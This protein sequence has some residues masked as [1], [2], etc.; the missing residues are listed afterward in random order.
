M[1]CFVL[2]ALH[3]ISCAISHGNLSYSFLFLLSS[4]I[5]STS[6]FVYLC[7]TMAALGKVLVTGGA[8]YIGTHTVVEMLNAGY[9]LVVLDSLVNSNKGM[10]KRRRRKKKQGRRRRK[11]ETRRRE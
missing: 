2:N 5:I 10:K 9:E 11:G 6:A 7:C 8:G 4:N 3:I 1:R